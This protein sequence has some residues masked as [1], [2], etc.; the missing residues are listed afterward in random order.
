MKPIILSVL[1]V[2]FLMIPGAPGYAYVNENYE[3]ISGRFVL[4]RKHA[5]LTGDTGTV[6]YRKES[7]GAESYEL[8]VKFNFP[9]H[10]NSWAAFKLRSS[11]PDLQIWE[12]TN[13]YFFLIRHGEISAGRII[14]SGPVEYLIRVNT[15]K[16]SDKDFHS[17]E[18]GVSN[19]DNGVPRL[20]FIVDGVKII[21][22]EDFSAGTFLKHQRSLLSVNVFMGGEIMIRNAEEDTSLNG[23]KITRKAPVTG[24]APLFSYGGNWGILQYTQPGAEQYYHTDLE[25]NENSLMLKGMGSI[26]YEKELFYSYIEFNLSLVQRYDDPFSFCRIML[27]KKDR[28]SYYGGFSIALDIYPDGKIAPAVF[29]DDSEIVYPLTETGLNFSKKTTIGVDYERKDGKLLM[30]VYVSPET[31]YKFEIAD[32]VHKDD[33]SGFFGFI[34]NSPALLTEI[35]SISFIGKVSDYIH[36]EDIKPVYLQQC[37]TIGDVL[38]INWKYR[39]DASEIYKVRASDEDGK[40]VEEVLYPQNSFLLPVNTIYR[41]LYLTAVS[42][43]GSVSEK[44]SVELNEPSV[45]KVIDVPRI[46]IR[47]TKNTGASFFYENSENEF[48]VNGVN[49]VELRFSD[50]ST[51]EPATGLLPA[52]YDP[53][54]AENML[55]VLSHS[56]FNTVR[57]FISNGRTNGNPGVAGLFESDEKISSAY[58]DNVADFLRLAGKYGIYV[59]ISFDENR[60]PENKYFK[61]LV[62]YATQ[63]DFLFN[64]GFLKAR[65]EFIGLFIKYI[66]EKDPLL[67]KSVLAIQAQNEFSINPYHD[68]FSQTTGEY[69]FYADGR[70]YD[71]SSEG[72]RRELAVSAMINYYRAIKNE[73]NKIDRGLLL[74][75]GTGTLKE[76][77]VDYRRDFGLFPTKYGQI[78]MTLIDYLKTDIDFIDVHIYSENDEIQ[79]YL[80]SILYEAGSTKPVIIGEYGVYKKTRSGFVDAQAVAVRI[81]DLFLKQGVK[82][83]VFWTFDTFSQPEYLTAMEDSGAFLYKL[84]RVDAYQDSVKKINTVIIFIVVSLFGIILFYTLYKYRLVLSKQKKGKL[85]ASTGDSFAG[86]PDCPLIFNLFGDMEI[87]LNGK[88]LEKKVFSSAKAKDFLALMLHKDKG[89]TRDEITQSLWPEAEGKNANDLFHASLYRLRKDLYAL[90]PDNDFIV[91]RNGIYFINSKSFFCIHKLFNKKLDKTLE[92]NTIHEEDALFLAEIASYYKG[93]YLGFIKG[94]WADH[95]REYYFRIYEQISIKICS[96]YTE[97][98]DSLKAVVILSDIVRK[99]PYFEEAWMCLLNAFSKLGD[100]YS[101]KRTFERYI[102]ILQEELGTH[103]SDMFLSYYKSLISK[104]PI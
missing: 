20:F 26:V 49:Y 61:N 22:Y 43:D 76:Y 4:S 29:F 97:G 66:K 79:E 67:L 42:M 16:L 50:H 40:M 27:W 45:I 71:M 96:F 10:S 31:A 28:N 87:Y 103:P 85:K 2:I 63:Q 51:F 72:Q 14:D 65:V 75:E 3:H 64:E 88:L 23:F 53:H 101:I 52:V 70:N 99:D 69:Y 44:V 58:M 1:L 62:P 78:P 46:I 94:D 34:N 35:E 59:I 56:G 18:F 55:R 39:T 89:L 37:T 38:M 8:E 7:S 21:E 74:C 5:L 25:R 11:N 41:R 73:L 19:T 13:T 68:P 57:V 86:L 17:V 91:F 48:V 12:N 95:D 93:D 15:E 90:L 6:I 98:S 104:E 92:K 30:F 47:N 33:S 81:R 77:E 102:K 82:G 80:D 32:P 100:I 9:D 84:S 54:L 36:N 24:L 83:V 60:V